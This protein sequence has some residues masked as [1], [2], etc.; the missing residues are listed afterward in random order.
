[1]ILRRDPPNSKRGF[2]LIEVLGALLIFSLGVLMVLNLT[3]ALATQINRAGL[4]TQVAST[5]QNRLDSLQLVPYDSLIV[6][7]VADTLHLYGRVF[8]RSHRI[9]QASA[10][11][12]EIEVTVEAEDGDGPSLTASTFVTLSW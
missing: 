8:D 2:T 10:L 7:T 4:R 11:V 6:G 5:V 12:K 1:M 9:L 3:G